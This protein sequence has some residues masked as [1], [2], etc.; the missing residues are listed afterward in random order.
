MR[1]ARDLY[2]YDG[3][4]HRC[5]CGVVIASYRDECSRCKNMRRQPRGGTRDGR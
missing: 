5:D 1:D 3:S 2:E 4:V